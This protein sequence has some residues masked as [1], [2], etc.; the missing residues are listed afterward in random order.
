MH[1]NK[2]KQM[3]INGNKWKLV[4]V[5]ATEDPAKQNNKKHITTCSEAICAPSQHTTT[6]RKQTET[7]GNKWKLVPVEATEDPAN[8]CNNKSD[9]N[10]AQC[11]RNIDSINL[12]NTGTVRT[13][14]HPT[15]TYLQRFARRQETETNGNKR[16]Q[17]ETC[18][19]KAVHSGTIFQQIL[20]RDSS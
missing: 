3:E 2:R 13:S 19:R 5:E 8:Q 4:P 14:L 11:N 20:K 1:G 15:G 7:N 12:I 18:S 10:A 9:R 6:A 17:T 16:K